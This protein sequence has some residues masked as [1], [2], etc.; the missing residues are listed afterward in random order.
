M[1]GA[2]A[3]AALVVLAPF[4]LGATS[5]PQGPRG[6]EVFR[7]QDPAI[8]ESSGLAWVGPAGDG[9]VATTNDSGDTGRVF[10]VD[11]VT[12]AT[13]GTTTWGTAVG[14]PEDVEALA[15]AGDDA[16]WVADIGDNLGRRDSVLV[17]R[18][19]V[20]RGDRSVRPAA[21]RLAW[22]RGPRDAETLLRHPR[23]GRLYL[24]D[25]GVLGG[26][27]A[28]APRRLRTDR[29]NPLRPMGPVLGLATDGAFWPDGRHVVL[30]SYARAVVYAF[31]S[32]EPVG[33]LPLPAQEQG[34]G[35][36]V[37]PD[38]RVLVSS[39]GLGRPVLEVR[40]P[41]RLRRTLEA[42]ATPSASPGTERSSGS[43]EPSPPEDTS[44]D[45]GGTG[46]APTVLV[47]GAAVAAVV[48]AGG[49]AAVVLRARRRRR[50]PAR[51]GPSA[52][53][54]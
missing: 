36:A 18:V 35:L 12:G 31:P 11:P 52:P 4:V 47:A 13:A 49:V 1:R 7:F 38:G 21:H 5:A 20:G 17:V 40:V 48:G 22:P 39:E 54:A 41:P 43:A 44:A 3:A 24:V 23:T 51:G 28:A 9:L 10:A 6:R 50:P 14:D 19:P 16:V 32:L 45:G 27:L 33:D 15:P 30:R 25:K 26:T 29:V 8:V 46:G 53:G 2:R 34:E 42:P 37:T